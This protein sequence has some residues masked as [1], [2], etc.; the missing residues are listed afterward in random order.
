MYFDKIIQI[1][2]YV[3]STVVLRNQSSQ[4]WCNFIKLFSLSLA[5]G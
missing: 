4:P 2:T 1:Y 5:M 3:D